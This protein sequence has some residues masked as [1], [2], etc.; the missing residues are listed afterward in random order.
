MVKRKGGLVRIIDQGAP[1]VK[2]L[3]GQVEKRAKG[4]VRYIS[5]KRRETVL[6]GTLK[7]PPRLAGKRSGE[8]LQRNPTESG[9]T[10]P[11]AGPLAS[12]FLIVAGSIGETRLPASPLRQ[13][14]S[15]R[16]DP[17]ETGGGDRQQ[18]P[19][20]NDEPAARPPRG[21]SKTRDGDHP[22]MDSL[23]MKGDI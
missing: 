13:R 1:G 16:P 18:A 14:Q 11:Y 21:S 5:C 3:V 8:A 4:R 15:V 17:G 23:A 20:R 7:L 12:L 2:R 10:H 6:S 9:S 22:D 19:W